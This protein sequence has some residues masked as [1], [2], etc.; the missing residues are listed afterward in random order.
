[1]AYK[2]SEYVFYGHFDHING[3]KYFSAQKQLFFV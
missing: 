3:F 1:M 2:Y